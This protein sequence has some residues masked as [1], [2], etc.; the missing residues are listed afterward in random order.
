[1][2]VMVEPPNMSEPTEKAHT[3]VI[4]MKQYGPIPGAHPGDG[5]AAP[6]VEARTAAR[7][8]CTAGGCTA[9]RACRHEH[10]AGT[11]VVAVAQDDAC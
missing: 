4:I 5:R 1:M 11:P 7:G 8:G 10:R 3:C 9:G 2:L 6:H